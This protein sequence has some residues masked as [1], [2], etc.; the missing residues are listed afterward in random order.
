MA[1]RVR[2]SCLALLLTGAMSCGGGP[3][4]RQRAGTATPDNARDGSS[5]AATGAAAASGRTGQRA[6]RP[7]V[8]TVEVDALEPLFPTVSGWERGAVQ[9]EKSDSPVSVTLLQLEYHKGEARIDATLV[10]SGFNQ[11][12]IEP[13]MLFVAQGYKK[14]TPT[15]YER[16]VKVGD[17]PAWER[18]DSKARN[19]EL[20]VLVSGRF[21]VQLDGVDIDDPAVL[22][23]LLESFDLGQL[24]QLK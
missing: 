12:Y 4:V 5:G 18:W 7:P 14:E 24:A 19:G 15:G 9:G 3:T 6:A 10:D 1:A 13:F 23:D 20:N 2:I 8:E 21:V 16:A 11:S 17:Y 22:H